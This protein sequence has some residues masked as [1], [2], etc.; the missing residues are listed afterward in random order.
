LEKEIIFTR[1]REEFVQNLVDLAEMDIKEL[2]WIYQPKRIK[3]R[4]KW[5]MNGQ[6]V[7]C[8]ESDTQPELKD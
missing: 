7:S 3:S 5:F 4:V 8:A 1:T 6:K 2:D